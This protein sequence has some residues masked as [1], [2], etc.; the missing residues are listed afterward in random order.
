MKTKKLIKKQNGGIT[1]RLVEDSSS[2]SIPKSSEKSEIITCPKCKS[3]AITTYELVTGYATIDVNTWTVDDSPDDCEPYGTLD[4]VDQFN[5]SSCDYSFDK[6]GNQ[7]INW[8]E[9]D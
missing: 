7:I 5:C 8:W 1:L 2:V 6:D 3:D 9:K 4:E